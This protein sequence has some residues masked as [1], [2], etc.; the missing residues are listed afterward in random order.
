[1]KKSVKILI[2]V[3]CLIIVGLVTFIV[4][5]KVINT[6]KEESIN[7]KSNNVI[8]AEN[9]NN[10]IE[11]NNITS[12]NDVKN[13]EKTTNSSGTQSNANTNKVEVANKA[14]REAL[15]D[16][17]W[18]TENIISEEYASIYERMYGSNWYDT[19]SKSL[20][21]AKLSSKENTPLYIVGESMSLR[22]EDFYLVSYKNEKV[23]SELVPC[24][25]Y[26]FC[27][28]DLNNRVVR[29]ARDNDGIA[30][31]RKIENGEFIDIAEI[32]VEEVIV[33]DGN[34]N[35][36]NIIDRTE[37]KINNEIVSKEEFSAFENK[38]NFVSIET[39]LTEEN[40]DKYVK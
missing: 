22:E 17:K 30:Y 10:E 16:E 20:V 40:I 25:E 7:N 34:G 12:T 4:V 38:Y 24:P 26:G 1:M 5:D 37:Y 11:S 14:I 19:E 13:E 9:N 29:A 23:I 6:K 36:T 2:V 33:D 8:V 28:F 18:I 32:S 21:F 3:L 27:E 15:K 39:K 35:I 31:Y